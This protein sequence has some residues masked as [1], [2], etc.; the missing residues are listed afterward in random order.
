MSCIKR[1]FRWSVCVIT[2]T[3]ATPLVSASAAG[4]MLPAAPVGSHHFS[5]GARFHQEQPEFK[6]PSFGDGDMT[7]LAAYEYHELYGSWQ[8]ALG[9]TPETD[10]D[11]TVDYILT[12]EINLIYKERFYRGGIGM[13]K[14]YIKW[15]DQSGWRDLYYQ[16]IVGVGFPIMKMNLNITGYYV[17]DDWGNIGKFDFGNLEYAAMLRFNF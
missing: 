3:T 13:L 4:S 6:N 9:Y 7:Y 15:E 11:E 5:V 16:F 2:L 8:F 14:D 17:F 10:L 12:P 1:L